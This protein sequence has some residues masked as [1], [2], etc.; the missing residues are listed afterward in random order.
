MNMEDDLREKL[1]PLGEAQMAQ[2]AAVCN[3]YP[4]LELIVETKNEELHAVTDTAG[5]RAS[6]DFSITV[7]RDII[8]A[9]F[10]TREEYLEE[11]SIFSLPV[12]APY[13]PAE[14]QENWW[15]IVGHVQTNTLLSIKKITTLQQRASL[16]VDFNI[17]LG[18]DLL[19]Q[20]KPDNQIKKVL[21]LKVYL[22]CDSY[23]GCD[24]EKQVIVHF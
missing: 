4:N 13:Y 24:L 21:E 7:R 12:V 3:R 19:K 14:K 18:E 22:I 8:E 2:L 16:T 9:D 17:S 11:L 5:G 6:V 15:V 20:E 23:V 10:S 1:V